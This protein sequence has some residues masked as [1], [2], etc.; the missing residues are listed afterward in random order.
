MNIDE[1]IEFAINDYVIYPAHGVGKIIDIQSKD[2]CGT[3]ML[4]YIIYFKIRDMQLSIPSTDIA[5]CGLRVPYSKEKMD[6]LIELFKKRLNSKRINNNKIS[7]NKRFAYYE[8]KIKTGDFFEIAEVFCELFL[9]VSNDSCSY[10]ERNLYDDALRRMVEEISVVY[11]ITF[12]DASQLVL[13]SINTE[14]I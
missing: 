8:T 2:I 14:Q 1:T 9:H 6:N 13:D 10:S 5:N 7:W 11:S 4:F 12:Q 3:R